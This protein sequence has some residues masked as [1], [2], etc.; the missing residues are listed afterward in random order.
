[1]WLENP[2]QQ[3]LVETAQTT[4]EVPFN[5]DTVMVKRVHA[6]L[7]RHGFINFGIFKRLKVKNLKKF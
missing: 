1:M 5:S 3:L 7:E 4:M 2:K 6:F